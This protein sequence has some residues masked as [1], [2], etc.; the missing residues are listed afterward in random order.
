MSK[1]KSKLQIHNFVK[2][3]GIP[4][5][6]CSYNSAEFLL[7]PYPTLSVQNMVSVML[8]SLPIDHSIPKTAVKGIPY[9][10][11]CVIPWKDNG[12]TIL[13]SRQEWREGT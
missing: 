6:G 1:K 11:D 10:I 3:R 5:H 13:K 2:F 4:C 9:C 12:A 7:I 8:K